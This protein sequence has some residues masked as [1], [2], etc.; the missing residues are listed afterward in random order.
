MIPSP[1]PSPFELY[2]N[3][4]QDR[5]VARAAGLKH[6][7]PALRCLQGHMCLRRVHDAKCLRC[8]EVEQQAKKAAQQ[9][10]LDRAT[11][12]ERAMQAKERAAKEQAAEEAREAR[13]AKEAARRAARRAAR[14]ERERERKK[15]K[16]AATRAANKVARAAAAAGEVSSASSAAPPA[17]LAEPAVELLPLLPPLW[18]G[19]AGDDAAPWE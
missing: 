13:E 15:A 6:Y 3:L 2:A 11:A 16:A 9:K 1:T 8:L 4:P 17:V 10:E 7:F 12:K 18:G 19:D 14:E 5:R